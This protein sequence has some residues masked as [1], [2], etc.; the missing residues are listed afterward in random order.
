ME[1]FEV[2]KNDLLSFV[3]LMVLKGE[4]ENKEGIVSFTKD[5][6]STYV[7]SPTQTVA[8]RGTLK[9]Q[10]T[11]WEE[12]GID[13]LGIVKTFLGSLK[14]DL[15]TLDHNKNK[16]KFA[17]ASGKV[18][19]A[20]VLRNVDYITNSVSPEKFQALLDKAQGNE[21]IL[22]SEQIEEII[23][24]AG[25]V[26]SDNFILKGTGKEITL[27]VAN[28]Q[29]QIEAKFDIDVD[30]TDFDV[31]LPSV[32]IDMLGFMKKPVTFSA[33]TDTPIYLKIEQNN[34]EFEYIVAPK[35]KK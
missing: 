7:V 8:S 16:L 15:V 33:K 2:S 32:V 5:A 26:K 28:N 11:D 3:E 31:K 29:N 22:K 4:A 12:L 25:T 23:K 13:D 10:F 30:V 9:G 21:F 14:G 17:D 34:C 18:K 19:A 1:K 24:Y 27:T 35:K 20:S 6:L